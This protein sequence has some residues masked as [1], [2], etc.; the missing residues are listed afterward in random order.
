MQL[1]VCFFVMRF[2]DCVKYLPVMCFLGC[3]FPKATRMRPFLSLR[4]LYVG[5]FLYLSGRKNVGPVA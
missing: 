5:N 1:F 4:Q 3:S 2:A